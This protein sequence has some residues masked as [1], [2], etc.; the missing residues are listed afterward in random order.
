[1]ATTGKICRKTCRRIRLSTGTCIQ[2]REAGST[3]E[4]DGSAAWTSARRREKTP[5]GQR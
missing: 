1:M 3:L 5:N 2:W 4:A